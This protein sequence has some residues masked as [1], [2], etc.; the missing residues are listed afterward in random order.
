MRKQTTR[1]VRIV[2]DSSRAVDGSRATERALK[3]I[4]RQVARRRRRSAKK[5]EG[6]NE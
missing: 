5:S 4:E 2:V 1:V 6:L 3:S